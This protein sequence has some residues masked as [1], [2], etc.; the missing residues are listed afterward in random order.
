MQDII[1]NVISYSF[2]SSNISSSVCE[3]NES[4]VKI[5][6]RCE[7]YQN[8]PVDK[9]FILNL[10]KGLLCV[11]L[12]CCTKNLSFSCKKTPTSVSRG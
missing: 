2:N 9:R 5:R 6:H 11:E 7:E 10:Y 3:S 1:I 4:M 8:N 12:F